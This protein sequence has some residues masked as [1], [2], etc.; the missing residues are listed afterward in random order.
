MKER[1][2]KIWPIKIFSQKKREKINATKT[3]RPR[4]SSSLRIDRVQAKVTSPIF[5]FSPLSLV[6]II[7]LPSYYHLRQVVQI[8][9]GYIHVCHTYVYSGAGP[10]LL[11]RQNPRSYENPPYTKERERERSEVTLEMATKM[12]PVPRLI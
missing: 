3:T 1:S 2:R 11:C 10:I 4:V 5:A 9:K 7:I 6:F 12:E 8:I